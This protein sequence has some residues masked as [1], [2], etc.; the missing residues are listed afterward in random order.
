MEHVSHPVVD[1]GSGDGWLTSSPAQYLSVC[2]WN[3]EG[4]T[5]SKLYEVCQYMKMH[6]IH[7]CCIQ[8]VRKPNS[9]YYLTDD[10]F[11]V[12]LSGSSNIAREWAGVGFIVSPSLKQKVEFLQ[13]DNRIAS[14]KLRTTGGKASITNVYAPTNLADVEVKLQ[15]YELLHTHLR[16]FSANGL[17]IIAGDFNARFG[18]RRSGEEH[19]L[20]EFSCGR[21]AVH[22]VPLPNRD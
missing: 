12:I 19:F 18:H 2:S 16:S 11:T 5:E 6:G 7:V 21:E 9:D 17:R 1:N 10:G 4:L 22:V 20:G 3:V 15:F 14:I 13:F 8:E